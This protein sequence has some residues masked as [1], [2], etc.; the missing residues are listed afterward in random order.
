MIAVDT[1]ILIYGHRSEF[2]E[3]EAARELLASLADGH[4]LWAVPVFCLAEFLRVVTHPAI[5]KPP[6]NLSAATHALEALLDS[7]S[8]RVLTPGDRFPGLLLQTATEGATT[9]NLVFDAQI[10]AVCREQ[11]VETICTN[12]RD[13]AK[14]PG[15]KVQ[16]LTA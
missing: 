13:F 6:S 7:A 11:G 10:V 3:H 8:V 2:P 12:D 14:F 1:N 4:Q 16:R 15:I 9:G 5:L